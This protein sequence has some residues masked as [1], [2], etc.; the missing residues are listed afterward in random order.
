MRFLRAA[1][2]PDAHVGETSLPPFP[3]R[4]KQAGTSGERSPR[5]VKGVPSR[6]AA[7][8]P[9]SPPVRASA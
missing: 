5:R 2:W 4:P 1:I 3:P 8:R 6:E 7:A 9:Q